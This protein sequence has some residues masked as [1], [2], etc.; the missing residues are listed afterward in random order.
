MNDLHSSLLAVILV[1]VAVVFL[2]K[3]DQ[4]IGGE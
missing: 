3:F 2:V 4:A 1:T